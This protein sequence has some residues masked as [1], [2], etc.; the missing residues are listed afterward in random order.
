MQINLKM[1]KPCGFLSQLISQGLHQPT[2][3]S[4]LLRY[5]KPGGALAR[6]SDPMA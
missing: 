3:Q 1:K 4:L 5:F 2:A 6:R